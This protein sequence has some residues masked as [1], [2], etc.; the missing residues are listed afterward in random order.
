MKRLRF[1]L[2][3][4]P[5]L[6]LLSACN[7]LKNDV[8]YSHFEPVEGQ[9]WRDQAEYFFSFP[10]QDTEQK[11]EVTGVIRYTPAFGLKNIPVG[12]V[13]EDADSESPTYKTEVFHLEFSESRPSSSGGHFVIRE[14]LFKIEDSAS[15]PKAGIYTYSLRH[16]ADKDS[17]TGLAEVG[18]I[19]RRL[20][21]L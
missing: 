4:V 15:F 7:S 2:F 11:Y 14:A 19:V 17:I 20:G 16:L 13:K 8:I 10:I 1:I 3:I 18:L 5:V 6:T 21:P 9:V 12:I